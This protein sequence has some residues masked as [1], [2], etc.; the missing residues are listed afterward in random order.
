MNSGLQ[1]Q[2]ALREEADERLQDQLERLNLLNRVTRS[3]GERQDL[4]SIFQVVVRS[5]E[6]QLPADFVCI[7][8]HDAGS[9][10]VEH[11]GIKSAQL[12]Q[13]LGMP[14][15]AR[16]PIDENGLSH[17]VRGQLVYEPRLQELDFPFPRRL[18]GAG[19]RAMVISPLMI[20]KDVI[21]VLVVSRLQP[22]SFSST[23]CEFQRQLS[24]QIALASRHAQL[25]DNLLKAYDDLRLTQASVAQQERLRVLGQMASG[26]AHDINNAISPLSLHTASLMESETGLSSRMRAY[27]ETVQRVTNDVAATMARLREF[28]REREPESSMRP[29]DLNALVRQTVELTRARWIDMPQQRGITISVRQE[30]DGKLA[31][32]LGYDSELREALT[33]LIFNAVDALPQGGEI[34][35]R[36]RNLPGPP[37]VIV[38]VTD[39]GAGMDETTVQRCMEPFFTTKGERGTGL[40]LAMVL[41]TAKRHAASVDIDSAPG[42]GTTLRLTFPQALLAGR[43]RRR[44]QAGCAHQDRCAFWS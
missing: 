27:L 31:P 44:D 30:L 33:N 43:A 16:I 9:L 21:G 24:E 38:E 15:R 10:T 41:G 28:Y 40:G 17:C 7:L 23:D 18:T 26:I 2:I 1:E 42:K 8:S 32:V 20:E 19:L 25:Y 3:I 11:V 12:A 4:R 13:A 5:L 36:T 22:D 39:N 29:V 14:E 34:L 37:R 6:E 35:L